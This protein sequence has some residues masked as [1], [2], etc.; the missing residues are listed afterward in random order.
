MKLI[1]Q[2]IKNGGSLDFQ[3]FQFQQDMALDIGNLKH[4]AISMASKHWEIFRPQNFRYVFSAKNGMGQKETNQSLTK[5]SGD[6]TH[7]RTE[8]CWGGEMSWKF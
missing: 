5:T 4:P 2:P 1:N 7:K 3:G 6:A 8:S